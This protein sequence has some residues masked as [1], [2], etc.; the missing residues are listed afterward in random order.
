MTYSRRKNGLWLPSRPSILRGAPELARTPI[1]IIAAGGGGA[2]AL[3]D[4]VPIKF[5]GSTYLSRGAGL[6]G[7]ADADTGILSVWLRHDKAF[8][9]QVRFVMDASGDSI[10][11]Y[12]AH[13][14]NEQTLALYDTITQQSMALAESE[15]SRESSRWRH[16][17]MS[18]DAS[19][20]TIQYYVD[21]V[22]VGGSPVITT[23]GTIDYT[24]SN[25]FIGARDDAAQF[26]RGEMSDF[27]LFAGGSFLDLTTTGNRRKFID[28]NKRPVSLGADGST[29]M[30]GAPIIYL[31]NPLATW[32]NNLG[33]GGNFTENGTLLAG[34]DFGPGPVPLL[35]REEAFVVSQ[36]NSPMTISGIDFG[37]AYAT[38]RCIFVFTTIND[39][40]AG[41]YSATIGGVACSGGTGGLIRITGSGAGS[42]SFDGQIVMIWA[43]V[44]SDRYLDVVLT[45][46]TTGGNGSLFAT[47]YSVDSSLLADGAPTSNSNNV[48]GATSNTVTLNTG[49]DG[50]VIAAF[51][52]D[53]FASPQASGVSVTASTDPMVKDEY[54]SNTATYAGKTYSRRR[55]SSAATPFSVT[56]GWTNS[57]QA[58]AALFHW[59]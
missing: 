36:A 19:T 27:Y 50:F 25:W 33:T 16:H 34:D 39:Y 30:G 47:A 43:D 6:T 18:W 58:I 14:A 54:M 4:P 42:S 12:S 44:S 51:T 37:P 1:G 3:Y 11:F 55:A 8:N 45:N 22:A 59:K 20:D 32:Q 48:T 5:D 10:Q 40:E 9:D 28:A 13:P 38:R 56:F 29:P 41:P 49:A 31:N 21:D 15:G 46:M 17:L 53:F 24:Q 35:I 2:P 57:S 7:A 26:W 52:A 23:G